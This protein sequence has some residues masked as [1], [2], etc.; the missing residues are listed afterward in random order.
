MNETIKTIASRYS[1]RAF[2]DKSLS[3]DQLK[4]IAKAGAHSP[5]AMNRQ[6]W[7]IVVVTNKEL[8]QELEKEAMH[9]LEI[10][11]DK[12]MYDRIMSRGGTVFYNA[13]CMV[14][15]PIDQEDIQGTSLDCGIV[16]QNIALTA[17]SLDLGNVICGMAR[18]ALMGD[19]NEYF[20]QKLGF[21]DGYDFGISILIGYAGDKNEPHEIDESKFSFID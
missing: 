2:T 14:F 17:S 5:S 8:L 9:Q 13:P 1:C 15:I 18:L 11:E 10:M 12:T 6:G 21:P 20:K 19:K 7:K 4:A 3:K 16:A